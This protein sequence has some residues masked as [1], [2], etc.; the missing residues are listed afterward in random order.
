MYNL[1]I[2][3]LYTAVANDR[4]RLYTAEV[5]IIN[6]RRAPILLILF[7]CITEPKRALVAHRLNLSLA[8]KKNVVSKI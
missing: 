7:L 1:I 6:V 3:L 4:N 8:L 5:M 2:F